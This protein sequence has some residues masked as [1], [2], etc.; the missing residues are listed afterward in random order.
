MTMKFPR[1][2]HHQCRQAVL[3]SFLLISLASGAVIAEDSEAKSFGQSFKQLGKEIGHVSRDVGREIGHTSR[4]VAKEIGHATRD[5]SKEVG[6]ASR[7]AA[8]ETN[9]WWQSLWSD[10]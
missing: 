4:D 6:H 2:S 3:A 10:E 5:T 1:R 7:D 8:K 9:S